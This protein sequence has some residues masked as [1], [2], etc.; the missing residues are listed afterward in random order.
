[1]SLASRASEQQRTQIG[2][3]E[4]L[5]TDLAEAW[6]IISLGAFAATVPEWMRA[7]TALVR[8]FALASGALAADYYET[9]RDLAGV[10]GLYT[11]PEVGEV[12]QEKIDIAFRWATR[13]L[14]IPEEEGPPP[15][16]QRL[17]AAKS[18]ADGAASKL[19]TDAAREAI[20]TSVAQDPQ[21]RGWVRYAAL[22][23]CYFCKL[24]A[25]RGPVYKDADAA[26]RNTDF[27]GEGD[28]KFH[29]WC[30][31]HA[32]PIFRGQ[33]YEPPAHVAA[34]QRL[35]EESTADATGYGKVRAFRRAVEA[36]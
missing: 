14:W 24:M 22:G 5:L 29:D 2:L 30:Q 31:C 7:A 8:Q 16:E 26:G 3:V 33:T 13:D 20:T 6:Q 18:K 10:R 15:I 17:V 34:W 11:P 27:L 12:P 19:V 25:I 1:V 21:A 4:E 9:E 35:Y 32:A 28:F 36:A 23:A